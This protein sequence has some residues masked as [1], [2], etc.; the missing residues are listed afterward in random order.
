MIS[1]QPKKQKS[2]QATNGPI[3]PAELARGMK[4]GEVKQIGENMY[5]FP[6]F[7]LDKPEPIKKSSKSKSKKK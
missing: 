3:Y 7:I 1:K 2:N 4:P 5:V 6:L